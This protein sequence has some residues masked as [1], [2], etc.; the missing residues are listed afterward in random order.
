MI[1]LGNYQGTPALG[2]LCRGYFR[3]GV[4]CSVKVFSRHSVAVRIRE[5][6][7]LCPL[8]DSA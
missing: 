4:P 1:Q 3:I 2:D 7:D 6:R 5:G 8:Y